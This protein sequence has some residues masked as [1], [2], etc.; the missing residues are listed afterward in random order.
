MKKNTIIIVLALF[1]SATLLISCNDDEEHSIKTL[2][3]SSSYD[4]DVPEPSGL[5][6]SSGKE[7]LYTVSDDTNDIYKITFKGKLLSTLNCNAND[8]EGVTYDSEN[9]NLWVVEEGNRILLKCDLQGNILTETKL[10]IPG[11]SENKGLEGITFNA[12]N[13]HI[14]CL[15]EASPGLLIELDENQQLI[16]EYSLNFADDYSGIF[17]DSRT[18]SIWIISDKSSTISKCDLEGN[19]TDTYKLGINKAEGVVVDSDNNKIYVISDSA[20]K[21]YVFNF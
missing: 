3:L 8:L 16:N 11:A 5:S 21:L 19:A 17:H 18:D 12:T 14:Y 2:Y 9:K 20:E 1:L 15:N 4:L 13:G 7:A 10:T 6:F